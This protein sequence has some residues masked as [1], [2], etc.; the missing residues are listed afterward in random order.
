M[1]Q[2]VRSHISSQIRAEMTRQGVTLPE[3]QSL[4]RVQEEIISEYLAAT[5][6]IS[7]SELRPIFRALGKNLMQALS[8]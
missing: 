4:S 8:P 1:S 3:L 2:Q 6:E 7:F 5:R